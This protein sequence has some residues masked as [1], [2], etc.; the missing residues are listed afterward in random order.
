MRQDI[1]AVVA[2]RQ[3]D[4]RDGERQREEVE[5]DEQWLPS[6]DRLPAA[7]DR[8]KRVAQPE[9]QPAQQQDAIKSR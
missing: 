6:R 4:D 7:R 5:R 8:S 1:A 3:V 2:E 9:V